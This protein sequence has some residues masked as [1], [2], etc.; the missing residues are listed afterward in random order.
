MA[1]STR[2]KCEGCGKNRQLRFFRGKRGTVCV[3]CQRKRRRNYSRDT[4]LMETYG[5]TGE[6]YEALLEA[7]GGVCAI[8]GG[9]R[10]YNLDVDHDHAVEQALVNQGVPPIEAVRRSIRGLL[11]KVCNRHL[12]PAVHDQVGLLMSAARYLHDSK[13]RELL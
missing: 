5:I 13:G 9:K 3:T 6:E 1:T 8:C 11:C 12:L 7:Q 2:R 4:R 10:P